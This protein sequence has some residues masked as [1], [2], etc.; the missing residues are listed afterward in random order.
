[1]LPLT[2]PCT[3]AG[4]NRSLGLSDEL[5]ALGDTLVLTVLGQVAFMPI[6]VL[7]AQLCP[8]VSGT[9]SLCHQRLPSCAYLAL[10]AA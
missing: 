1:M 3:C 10:G 7:A 9:L 2:R 8:E 4:V 5:F 6:L